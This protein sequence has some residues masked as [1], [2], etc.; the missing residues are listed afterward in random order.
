[1]TE[2]KQLDEEAVRKY[3]ASADPELN[4]AKQTA[5]DKC[6]SSYK[7]EL[8]PQVMLARLS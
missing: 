4:S 6:L 7:A 1:M 8:D 2:D 3:F 5:V